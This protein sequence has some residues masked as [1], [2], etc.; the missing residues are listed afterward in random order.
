[1]ICKKCGFNNKLSIGICPKG[2]DKNFRAEIQLNDNGKR[3]LCHKT[4]CT[5]EIE[6]VTFIK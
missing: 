6:G 1:M 2:T 4:Q 3:M 5:K